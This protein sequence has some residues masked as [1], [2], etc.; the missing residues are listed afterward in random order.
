MAPWPQDR[1]RLV[2]ALNGNAAAR[3]HGFA[4]AHRHESGSGRGLGLTGRGWGPSL[5]RR[6]LL[7]AFAGREGG[8]WEGRE[9]GGGWGGFR[10]RDL[11]W[12]DAKGTKPV[13]GKLVLP[14]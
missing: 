12:K 10:A 13:G 3:R 8:R 6:A 9:V 2:H 4:L 14:G 11:I 1:N 5:W 7:A